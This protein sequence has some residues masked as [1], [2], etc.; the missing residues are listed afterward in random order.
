MNMSEFT[1]M[2]NRQM[3]WI[4]MLQPI[5]D[6][7]KD[8]SIDEA[9]DGD[10]VDDLCGI[11]HAKINLQ[12]GNISNADYERILDGLHPFRISVLDGR[13]ED[14]A[15]RDDRLYH[16]EQDHIAMEKAKENK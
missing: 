15:D 8:G 6:E 5:I 16:E 2:A 13:K 9:L 11:I 3:N 4:E 12:E 7:Y 1:K 14:P 10:E